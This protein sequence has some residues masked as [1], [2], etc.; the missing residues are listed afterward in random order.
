VLKLF[1]PS[2]FAIFLFQL[3]INK[4]ELTLIRRRTFSVTISHSPIT[5]ANLSSISLVSI[6]RCSSP[7][8]N[9]VWSA[10]FQLSLPFA[11]AS[12]SF[13]PTSE[14]K[15]LHTTILSK[16]KRTFVQAQRSLPKSLISKVRPA[17]AHPGAIQPSWVWAMERCAVHLHQSINVPGEAVALCKRVIERVKDLSMRP[18]D[19]KIQ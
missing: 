4:Q 9:P 19:D 2:A 17:V 3:Q 10:S 11:L 16:L 5:L 14:V 1:Y 12:R 15:R 13:W 18:V 8:H 7:P 6:F